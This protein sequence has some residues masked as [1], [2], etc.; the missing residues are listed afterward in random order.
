MPLRFPLS[1]ARVATLAW[2]A[3]SLLVGA[4]LLAKHVV[5][6]P[7]PSADER[8][9]RS[10]APL[11]AADDQG[12]WLAIHV[13]YAECRCS[14]RVVTHLASTTRP[15][16]WHELVL[17]AGSTAPSASLS[18][19]YRV[20]SVAIPELARL[21]VVAAPL[22]VVL[23]PQDNVRYVGGYSERKQGPELDDLRILAAARQG[24]AV[25]AHPVFG[26]AMN[27]QLKQQLSLLTGL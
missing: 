5:A 19:R 26:C 24:S 3:G 2:F 13:L 27:E 12:Q 6:L 25:T 21:G 15:Q 10:L 7:A 18:E 17:W 4:A 1:I 22:L 20:K 9:G 16:G 8:L 11:R 23:D 14:Q